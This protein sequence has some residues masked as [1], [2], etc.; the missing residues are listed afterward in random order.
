MKYLLP[1]FQ[2]QW[3]LTLLLLKSPSSNLL[4]KR[5]HCRAA[6]CNRNTN[7]TNQQLWSAELLNFLNH[8]WI[9]PHMAPNWVTWQKHLSFGT[10]ISLFF[11]AFSIFFWLVKVASTSSMSCSSHATVHYHTEQAKS[12]VMDDHTMYSLL[13]VIVVKFEIFIVGFIMN[14]L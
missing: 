2:V 11:T 8:L 7:V 10:E 4:R 1:T 13:S 6:T 5:Q 3:N 14:E 12:M 9:K